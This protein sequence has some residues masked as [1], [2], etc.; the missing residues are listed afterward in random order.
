MEVNVY[1][2]KD[3]QKELS[4]NYDYIKSSFGLVLLMIFENKICYLGFIDENYYSQREVLEIAKKSFKTLSN[5]DIKVNFIKTDLTGE[6]EIFLQN[7]AN[8]KDIILI[9]T[10]F[11]INVWKA[12]LSVKFGQSISYEDLSKKLQNIEI[13][14]NYTRAT[15]NAVANNKI[16]YIVPVP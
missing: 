15:A 3:Y 5:K 7:S 4:I 16:S 12:L 9:G 14:K 2:L 11:Q 6:K 8:P 1:Y 10:A 13:G